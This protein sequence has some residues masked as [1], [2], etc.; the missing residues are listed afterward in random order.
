MA[1]ELHIAGPALDAV[2]LVHPGE[3]ELILGRDAACSVSLP[4][5]E[6]NVSRRH[7]AVW[8]DGGDLHY[9]VLSTVNGV[10]I[11]FGYAPPGAEGVLPAG[12]VMK[13]GD[14]SLEVRPPAVQAAEQDPWAVFDRGVTSD[15][16]L[17]RAAP[18]SGQTADFSEPA[19][20]PEEDPFGDWGF[21]STFGP[22]SSPGGLKEVAQGPGAGDLSS[23]YKGLG[24]DI[25]L[26]GALSP[27]ELETAGRAVRG[28]SVV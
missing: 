18:T 11:P 9:R 13:V 3:P 15:A 4:D 1:L 22:G 6:R 16:T 21:E 28:K 26:M 8:N 7:L 27:V 5:P 20:L 10:E 19:I 12:Q 25:A 24:L 17:P 23:F 14:Y 2:R